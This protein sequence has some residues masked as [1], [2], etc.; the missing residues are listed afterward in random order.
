MNET[1]IVKA[2]KK[3]D[4]AKELEVIEKEDLETVEVLVQLGN[5]Y[6]SK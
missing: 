6:K 2:P 4:E 3:F 5:L 1:E